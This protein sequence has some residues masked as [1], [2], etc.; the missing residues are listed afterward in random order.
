[1]KKWSG[2][3]RRRAESSASE[4]FSWHPCGPVSAFTIPPKGKALPIGNGNRDHERMAARTEQHFCLIPGP[5]IFCRMETREFT[6]VY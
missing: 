3:A 6:D 2:F 1:M 5:I 4:L